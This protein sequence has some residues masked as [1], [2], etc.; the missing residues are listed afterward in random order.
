MHEHRFL[1]LF[2]ILRPGPYCRQWEYMSKVNRKMRFVRLLL[3][4][5]SLPSLDESLIDFA[6]L[7]SWWE[8]DK[9][10]AVEAFI[11]IAS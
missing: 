10:Q 1:K 7:L 9:G 3:K 11:V 8:K 4:L 2:V 5:V 6:V